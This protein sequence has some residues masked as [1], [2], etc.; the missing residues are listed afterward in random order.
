MLLIKRCQEKNPKL[1]RVLRSPAALP[2]AQ[3]RVQDHL[4]EAFILFM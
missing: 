3:L 2:N 4:L 1:V